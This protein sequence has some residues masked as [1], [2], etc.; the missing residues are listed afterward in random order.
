MAWEGMYNRYIKR[1]LDILISGIALLCIFPVLPLIAIAIFW[2]DGFPILYRAPRCGLRGRIFF[3]CKFRTMIKNADKI[4]GGTTALR[5]PRIT[6]VGSFLRKTKLDELPQLVQVLTGKM[7]LV[8]PRPELLQYTRQYRGEELDILQVRPGITDY[9]SV[10]FIDLAS[11]VGSEN[12]DS[13][14]EELV[15]PVKNALRTEYA[16]KV[17]FR[18]DAEILW[19]TAKALLRKLLGRRSGG[20]GISEAEKH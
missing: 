20:N 7:S 19:L 8:G 1:M 6:K 5:D 16:H 3:I 10:K 18:T 11:L 12:A 9:S 4:G 2:E 17:S 15:L 13:R 14:Y